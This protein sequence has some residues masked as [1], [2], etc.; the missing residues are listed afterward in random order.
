VFLQI[1]RLQGRM[2]EL[3][4]SR[5]T[6]PLLSDAGS[7]KIRSNGIVNTLVE[8]ALGPNGKDPGCR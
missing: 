7:A 8:E 1:W 5:I 4:K 6:F 3:R 2:E